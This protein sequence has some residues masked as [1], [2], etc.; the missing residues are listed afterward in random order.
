MPTIHSSELLNE[1]RDAGKLQQN[2]DSIPS[3]MAKE[4]VPVI[5]VNPNQNRKINQIKFVYAENSAIY[6]VPA[7]KKAYLYGSVMSGLVAGAVQ[8][9]CEIDYGPDSLPINFLILQSVAGNFSSGNNTVMFPVPILMRPGEVVNTAGS[10]TWSY[11]SASI[12]IC[13][14][15]D[16]A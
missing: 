10:G 13:E 12:F 9:E 6:T 14:V 3:G 1:I 7:G 11:I 2:I 5:E 16:V 4:V 15:D 8:G